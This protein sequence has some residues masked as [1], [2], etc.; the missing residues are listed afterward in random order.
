MAPKRDERF[1]DRV[2]V[3]RRGTPKLVPCAVLFVDLL[4]VREMNRSPKAR[5]HLI[6]LERAVTGMYRDYLRPESPWPASF[7]SDTLV[8][9]SPVMPYSDEESSIGGLVL[10][11]AW[12]QLNLIAEGFFVRGGLSLGKFHIR[13]GLIFGPALADAAELEHDVAVHPRIVLSR[14]TEAS[15]R[16]DLRFYGQPEQSPQNAMLLCDSDGWT[17][18]NYLGLL[19]DEPDDPRPA[20]EA[21]RDQVTSRLVEHRGNKRV[22]EKYRWVAEYH[23][24]VV[25]QRL[26]SEPALLV[27]AAA[28]TWQFGAFA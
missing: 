13:D 24:E 23:N 26:P 17:F 14:E 18:I 15:Q 12:L 1:V 4:G 27:G 5:D 19:F 11:A 3:T 6:A 25:R 16:R 21:H 10:Q 22:W 28:M 2:F 8:L 7:F 20:L 9:A